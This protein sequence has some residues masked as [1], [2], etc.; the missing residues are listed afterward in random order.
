MGMKRIRVAT[1]CIMMFFAFS[2]FS[3]GCV[4]TTLKPTGDSKKSSPEPEYKEPPHKYYDFE[5]VLIPSELK[6]DIK[7]T[8][9]I[10][11]QGFSTG[12]LVLY[13]RVEYSSII[14]FFEINM[15]KDNW[16]LAGLF[17]SQRTIMLFQKENRW[18]VINITDGYRTKV[19]IWVSPRINA[20]EK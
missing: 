14:D 10:H 11:T 15:N 2:L 19:E 5:D 13:G 3:P 7:S 9:I 18:C 16:R 12:I 20:T 8:A 1:I 17:K 6:V 4:L